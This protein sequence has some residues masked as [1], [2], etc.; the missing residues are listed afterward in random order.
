[1]SDVTEHTP[2]AKSSSQRPA[3]RA[4]IGWRIVWTVMTVCMVEALVC[5]VSA[6]PVVFLWSQ[7]LS[8]IA[9]SMAI[10]L[11]L[12]SLMIIPSYVLFALFLMPVTVISTRLTGW[13][14]PVS[15]EVRIADMDWCLLNWARYTVAIH[16]VRLLAG[17][18][19]RGSPIWT[20][21][22]RLHGARFGRRVYINSISVTDYHLLEFGD[23]VVIGADAHI[24]GH[25][26]EAGLFKTG[27]VRLGQN[28][29]VGLGSV[30]DI[31]VEAGPHCQV[32]ALSLVPK[33][34]T[35]EAG[36]VYAGVPVRRI[37]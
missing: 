35:L 36:A 23:D 33:H 20:S 5:G 9:P 24:S 8:W 26:V 2:I 4:V 14:T 27:F 12:F 30:I 37:A 18:L 16:I 15:I 19:F 10:R 1:M 22:M 28:V 32:G 3:R 13:R 34:S 31:D 11:V 21:Y 7:L 29:T 25:T 17:T 6:L